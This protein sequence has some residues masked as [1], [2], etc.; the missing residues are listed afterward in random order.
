[1]SDKAS[2]LLTALVQRYKFS[3]PVHA[4]DEVFRIAYDSLGLDPAATEQLID[5]LVADGKVRVCYP[6]PGKEPYRLDDWFLE[7]CKS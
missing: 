6:E 1:M 4:R 3:D 5:T 2:K 7:R